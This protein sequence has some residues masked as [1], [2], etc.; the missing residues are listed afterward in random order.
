MDLDH[1][2]KNTDSENIDFRAIYDLTIDKVFSYVFLRTRDRE[3]SKEIVQ[4][5]YLSLWQ[6]LPKF[7]YISVEHFYG[8]LFTVVRRKLWKARIKKPKSVSL[9]EVYDFIPDESYEESKEDYRKL[10]QE[11]SSL[12]QKEKLVLELRYFSNFTFSEIAYALGIKE[13][14][15][16]VIHYRAI[17]KLKTKVPEYEI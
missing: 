17:N 8:F 2:F 10:L 14:N 11:I 5:I 4:E 13:N 3:W 12:K 6:S 16:K 15:V 1:I 9:E 7:K